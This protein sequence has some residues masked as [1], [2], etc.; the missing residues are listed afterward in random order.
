MQHIIFKLC[1]A[2]LFYFG[3]T[4]LHAQTT[5]HT[6]GGDASGS[7]GKISYSVGQMIFTTHKGTNG[8]IEQGVQHAYDIISGIND[9]KFITLQCSAYPNPTNDFLTLK[10]EVQ[11]KMQFMVSLFDPNGKLLL[12]RQTDASETIIPMEKLVPGTYFLKVYDSK[13]VIKT[14]KIVKN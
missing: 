5:V 1:A 13:K 3:S 4:G 12:N 10:I 2:F 6:S 8:S 9:A 14:F 7:G 11:A